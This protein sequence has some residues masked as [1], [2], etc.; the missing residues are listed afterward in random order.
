[1]PYKDPGKR[2]EFANRK[3]FNAYVFRAIR[4]ITYRPAQEIRMV[5]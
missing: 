2:R 4:S 5:K 1:M 3:I